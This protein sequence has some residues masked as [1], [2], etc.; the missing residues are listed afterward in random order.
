MARVLDSVTVPIKK[1]G[2]K[3]NQNYVNNPKSIAPQFSANTAYAAGQYVYQEKKFYRFTTDHPAGAWN[4]SHVTEVTVGS[5]LSTLKEDIDDISDKTYNLVKGILQNRSIS[6]AGKY[7]TGS[8]GTYSL[9]YA[10]VESG[11]TYT[12]TTNES[13]LVYAFFSSSSPALGDSSYDGR[14]VENTVRTFTAPINGYVFTR[15][16]GS[17]Y[18][19]QIVEGENTKPYL[20]N[21]TAVDYIARQDIVDAQKNTSDYIYGYLYKGE[22]LNK[23]KMIDGYFVSYSSG[24]LAELESFCVTDFIPVKPG[25]HIMATG[26]AGGSQVAYYTSNETYVTGAVTN[27]N[28]FDVPVNNTIAYMRWC[29]PIANKATA[30]LIAEW[31]D[32]YVINS[33]DSLLHGVIT[34]Y[35]NKA[36]KII[37]RPGVYD[38]ISDYIDEYGSDY[39]SSYSGAYNGRIHGNYDCG[40]WIEN[41]EIYFD[42][43]AKVV[44]KYNDETQNVDVREYFSAFAVGSNTVIDGLVLDAENLR[45]GIHPDFHAEETETTIFRNCDLRHKKTG[46]NLH[47]NQAIGAGLGVHSSWVVENCIFRSETDHPVFRIHNNVS[48][49][50]ESRIIIKDCYVVGE[51]YI[52]LNSYSTSEL[53]TIAMVS[54][55]SWQTPVTVGKETAGSNDNITLIEWN[56]ETRVSN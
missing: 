45:Y 42:A 44:C 49:N 10:P 1:N 27:A 21:L 7:D 20:P 13:I 12:A 31:S 48:E 46:T 19:A 29:M 32:T 36:K 24:E 5:E 22:L 16:S 56:N 37:V 55:C 40:V 53:Q 33:G 26:G 47:N 2:T 35:A 30:S 4:A 28:G 51:G 52:L 11:K 3:T 43:G 6:S 39:F 34:A 23:S 25:T 41:I 8:N 17:E 15:I 38:I 50:A 14:H 18:K 9:V 54:N